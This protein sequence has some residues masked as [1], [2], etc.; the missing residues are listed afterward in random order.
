MAGQPTPAHPAT[1]EAELEASNA[2]ASVPIPSPIV[3]TTRL[4]IR[5][6]HPQDAPSMAQ[7]ANDPL[8]A[9]NM[10]LSFPDPYTLESANTWI[11]MNLA[12]PRQDAFTVCERSSP[13]VVIGGIGLKPGADV[14]AHTAEVGFWMGRSHWGKGYTTEALEGFTKWTF[15]NY[16]RDGQR[17]TRICANVFS[18]N[19]G[20]M[21][22][23]EKCGYAKEGV[24]KGHG[25]KRGQ[26]Y[27]FHLFGLT[28]PDWEKRMSEVFNN[29]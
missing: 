16:V 26:V 12:L 24:L 23:F 28:K 19:V 10:S 22:C 3:G 29:Y 13:D 18:G 14:S 11:S 8:V 1:M 21:R 25:E 6:M 17:T 7:S 2:P 9:K 5:S 4:I 27:D 15:Q 20:S